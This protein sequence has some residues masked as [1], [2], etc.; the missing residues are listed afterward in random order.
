MSGARMQFL[1]VDEKYLA[2]LLS[3]ELCGDGSPLGDLEVV[4]LLQLESGK[5]QIG[6]ELK[7]EDGE[8]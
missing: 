8:Q 3:E 2:D 6:M 4:S 5:F 7:N 1:T